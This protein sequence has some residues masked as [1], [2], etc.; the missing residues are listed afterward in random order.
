MVLPLDP[1]AV[2]DRELALLTRLDPEDL[3][4]EVVGVFSFG[5]SG[6]L[7]GASLTAFDLATGKPKWKKDVPGGVV[8]CVAIADGLAIC[9]ATDGKVRAYRL[10]D[11]D[12]AWIYDA[13]Y[14]IFAPPAVAG[15]SLADYMRS[16]DRIER[17]Q[18]TLLC[19]GHGPWI[20]EPAAKIAEYREHRLE[21]ERKLVAALETGERSRAALLE[22]GWSDVA[23][24]MKP[25]AALAMQAHL[26]KLA[27]EG[28]RLNDLEP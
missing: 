13:K 23:E 21:R 19:P 5:E 4:A 15:G 24:S 12:R 18:P 14:N 27:G 25:A 8:G 10:A 17:L 11:G 22:A 7:A 9:T 16:L 2:V 26:E 3:E 6:G 28:A 1:A 20:T